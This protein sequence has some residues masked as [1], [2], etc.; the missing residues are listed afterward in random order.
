MVVG[1]S[2]KTG[3]A[4]AFSRSLDAEDPTA[5][6]PEEGAPEGIWWLGWCS[7]FPGRTRRVRRFTSRSRPATVD[8]GNWTAIPAGNK[9]TSGC[10]A[11][12]ST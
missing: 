7:T 10:K 4:Q 11:R 1:S 2:R 6:P 12:I 9:G 8:R 3:N 5:K